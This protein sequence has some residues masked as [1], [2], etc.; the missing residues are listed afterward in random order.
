M[1]TTI[2]VKMSSGVPARALTWKYIYIYINDEQSDETLFSNIHCFERNIH[3]DVYKNIYIS[4][5]CVLF[6]LK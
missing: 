4:E 6:S 5:V 2:I 1:I 3:L